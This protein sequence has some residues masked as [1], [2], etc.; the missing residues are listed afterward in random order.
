MGKLT[1]E[2]ED[3]EMLDRVKK[4]VEDFFPDAK[5]KRTPR[6]AFMKN[7]VL[8][9]ICNTCGETKPSEDFYD[10]SGVCKSCMKLKAASRC[11][12]TRKLK[13]RGVNDM[14]G[15]VPL[16][17]WE[18]DKYVT[19]EHY[20][21]WSAIFQRCYNGKSKY[22]VDCEVVEDWWLLS[23]FWKWMDTKEW[24]RNGEKF[25]LDKDLLFPGNT[26][27]GPDTC[28]FVPQQINTMFTVRQAARGDL[29]L[30][31]T[32]RK[33]TNKYLVHCHQDGK[34]V[35]G[36]YFNDPQIA[37][38]VWQEMKLEEMKLQ[39][40]Q[41]K[42]EIWLFAIERAIAILEDDLKNNKETVTLVKFI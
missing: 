28:M 8:C 22:H 21:T 27:Y 35:H 23:E 41:N 12:D 18:G 33:D 9:K 14:K 36:G 4:F 13:G 7:G 30:G 25:S 15:K 42:D 37:H 39:A 19:E 40:I 34:I 24:K 17:W 1:I 16:H 32:L 6:K 26:L 38:K 3:E 29:P 10:G 31:V 11:T 2:L 20:S 5:L